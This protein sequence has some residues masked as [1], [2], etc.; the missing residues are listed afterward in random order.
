[1][2]T[3]LTPSIDFTDKWIWFWSLLLSLFNEWSLSQYRSVTRTNVKNRYCSYLIAIHR[4]YVYNI[5]A[6]TAEAIDREKNIETKRASVEDVVRK[7][8]RQFLNRFGWV[9]TY[10]ICRYKSN[11]FEKS[12]NEWD[13]ILGLEPFCCKK[14]NGEKYLASISWYHSILLNLCNLF[15]TEKISINAYF[16]KDHLICYLI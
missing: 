12:K 16:V 13:W 6:R 4:E 7:D 1:M 9:Y 10:A 2:F 11:S 15:Y 8:F 14:Q 3:A 5:Y